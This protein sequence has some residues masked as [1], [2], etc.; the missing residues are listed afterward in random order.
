V[1]AAEVQAATGVAPAVGKA[2][3][4]QHP[5][6]KARHIAGLFFLFLPLRPSEEAIQSARIL[7]GHGFSRAECLKKNKWGFS[8]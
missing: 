5:L 3:R 8:L 7:K 4:S 1:G 6:G 2:E